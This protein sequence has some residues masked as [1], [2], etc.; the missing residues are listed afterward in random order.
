MYD[1]FFAFLENTRAPG[2]GFKLFGPEHLIFLA[3]IAVGIAV[4]CI[5]YKRL[6]SVRRLSMMRITAVTILLMEA[7]KQVLVIFQT[8]P[9][10]PLGVLPF[11]LCGL[12]IFVEQI[13]AIKPNKTT[14]EILYSL[15]IPGAVAALLFCNWTMYPIFNFHGLQ[16]F[17]IHGLHIAFPAMLIYGGDFRP[18]FS[19]IWRPALFL[20]IIVPPIYFLNKAIDTNFFF[21]N[22]GSEGSPLEIL[23]NLMGNPGFL[24][25][26]AGLLLVVWII[27]Y[28][29]F[30]IIDSRKRR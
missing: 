25:G 30:I 13:H 24:V 10:Y 29:P 7:V 12:S 22:A 27:I 8:M 14:G 6:D 20:L 26:F 15:G 19:Q 23:I 1:G 4:M 28:L 2:S 16:S 3:L 18:R 11:H 5:C 17:I 21:V 9:N